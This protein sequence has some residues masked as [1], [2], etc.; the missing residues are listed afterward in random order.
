MAIP[1][2]TERDTPNDLSGE[3]RG[4]DK[5]RQKVAF[6]SEDEIPLKNG[7]A[8]VQIPVPGTVKGTRT[9]ITIQSALLGDTA[10]FGFE[11]PI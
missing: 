7:Y 4:S 8:T 6:E 2:D 10:T 3:I 1:K 9:E 11:P 5:Y